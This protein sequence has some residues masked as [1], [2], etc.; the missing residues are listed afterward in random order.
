MES[1]SDIVFLFVDDEPDVLSS[2]RRFLH[3]EPYRMMFAES[4]L[5]ALEIMALQPVA[6][7]VS[8]LRMPEMDGLSLLKEVKARFPETERLILSATSDMDQI[9]DAIDSGDVFRFI[10][11]PLEPVSFKEIIRE[12]VDIYLLKKNDM[13]R[14][15]SPH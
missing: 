9:I 8:D 5:K 15:S 12:A 3:R 7:I 2:L 10:Q 1:I 6:I 13:T 11:K 4:G 14:V